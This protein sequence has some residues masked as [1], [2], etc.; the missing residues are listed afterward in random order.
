[1]CTY[2]KPRQFLIGFAATGVAVSSTT[3]RLI[4]GGSDDSKSASRMLRGPASMQISFWAASDPKGCPV[5]CYW[6]S[7]TALALD[8]VFWVIYERTP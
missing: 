4:G 5:N 3:T 1:M 2:H 8:E 7:V 6:P